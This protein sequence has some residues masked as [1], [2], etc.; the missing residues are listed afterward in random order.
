MPLLGYWQGIAESFRVISRAVLS[1]ADKS[2]RSVGLL[3]GQLSLVHCMLASIGK[4]SFWRRV[5]F[6]GCRNVF[7]L[8]KGR[9]VF[10]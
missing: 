10:C 7:P 5:Y 1:S 4:I 6:T 2:L 8:E 9:T 3:V